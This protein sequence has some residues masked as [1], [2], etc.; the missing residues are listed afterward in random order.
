MM[1]A[2]ERAQE[3][4]AEGSGNKTIWRRLKSEG[5]RSTKGTPFSPGSIAYLLEK[6]R[7]SENVIT[8]R[9]EETNPK[10]KAEAKL[11]QLTLVLGLDLTADKKL[12]VI[13]ELLS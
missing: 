4:K 5:Y 7:V 2:S 6:K 3:L 12:D 13:K 9:T 10:I 1:N 11:T 8:N